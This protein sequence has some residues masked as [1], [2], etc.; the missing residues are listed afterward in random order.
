MVLH[1][2]TW[3]GYAGALRRY[4]AGETPDFLVPVTLQSNGSTTPTGEGIPF[5]HDSETEGAQPTEAGLIRDG[6][7]VVYVAERL[8]VGATFTYRTFVWQVAVVDYDRAAGADWPHRVE[9]VRHA[10]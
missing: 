7:L 6:R 2:A 5:V 3:A 9:L 10:K 1:G 4:L 8:R